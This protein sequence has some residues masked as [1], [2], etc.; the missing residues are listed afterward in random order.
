MMRVIQSSL[1][2]LA[3]LSASIATPQTYVPSHVTP[4]P[5][6][7]EFRAAWVASVANIDWPSRKNLTTAEQRSELI[8]ILD[9]AAQLKLNA[10]VLQVRPACDAL[11]QSSI[12]PW[13]EYLTGMMGKAPQPFYDPLSFAIEEAHKR[14]IELH[15]WFNPY[16][17]RHF[18]GESPVSN[19]HISKKHPELVKKY[20]KYLWLDPGEKKVQA[21]C[22]SVVMDV[23][24]RYD[25]DGIHFDDYFYPYQEQDASGKDIDFPD[26]PSWEKYGRHSGMSRDDWRRDNVNTFISHVYQAIKAEKPWVKFGVSPFGIWRPGFPQRVRG[27]DAYAKLYAD[28]K[29]WLE[30]GWLDYLAPQ[31]YWSIAAPEQSFDDLLR[32]WTAQN[33]KGRF[34]W[35]GLDSTKVG[36]KWKPEEIVEQIRL[37][38]QAPHSDGNILWSVKSLLRNA[39]YDA[40]LQ[41]QVYSQPALVP[42]ATWLSAPHIEKPL[43]SGSVQHGEARLV[44][45]AAGAQ[46]PRVWLLQTRQA[47]KWRSQILPAGT[48]NLTLKGTTPEVIA[49]TPVDRAGNLGVPAALEKK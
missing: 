29:K 39:D 32:W 48:H 44:L 47:G 28:S 42:A 11:Y 20:G 4:P 5:P 2:V 27:Y 12:E 19:N 13:S 23:L 49:V 38:R 10:I 18:S 30:M 21:H 16:R 1:F 15:A 14:G 17:A 33:P 43:L 25:V 31:L 36:S 46:L 45:Q 7:R 6:L 26:E 3:I 24:N 37:T 8:A 41:Q 9:R 35:P 40:V 22:L 34:V